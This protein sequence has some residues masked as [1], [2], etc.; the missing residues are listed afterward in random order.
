[1]TLSKDKKVSLK[2]FEKNQF[3]TVGQTVQALGVDGPWALEFY[4]ISEIFV[5]VF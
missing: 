4:L 2:N 1:V 3:S 5:K